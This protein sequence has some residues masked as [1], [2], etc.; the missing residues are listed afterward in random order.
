[1]I[2]SWRRRIKRLLCIFSLAVLSLYTVYKS[3]IGANGTL[4]NVDLTATRS[5][6]S[7]ESS[8]LNLSN[9]QELKSSSMK[10]FC[11][12]SG[13][14][15]EY[16]LHHIV[17]S[18]SLKVLYCSIPK[19]ASRQLKRLFYPNRHTI[20]LAYF[21]K[22]EQ[23]MMLKTYFKF[24]LV[25]EPFERLLSSY[26]DKFLHPRQEDRLLLERHG[27]NILRNFRPNASQRSLEQ[28]NDI[29]F[30]EFV[31]YLVKK[32]SEW[33]THGVMDQHWGNYVNLCGM[34]DIKYDFIGH[35]ETLEQDLA[36]FT[37]AARLS[38]QDSRPFKA[39]KHTP[40]NTSS[41]L[42]KYYSQIPLEWIDILG[43]IYK[44]S[45]DMFG[46]NFPGPLKSLYENNTLV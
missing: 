32:G 28:L 40:S 9:L 12:Q 6:P 22:Q 15:S 38:V 36:D 21:S 7:V 20:N 46:Y 24:A 44:T 27:R 42:L 45:F 26:K 18:Q 17:V 11:Q 25:R 37:A 10:R 1:M 30:R 4:E 13:H 35:Y 14:L 5:Y 3:G 31:E 29:T 2:V 39:Y 34:C 8:K 23:N 41:S 43:R 19:C 16:V 33:K